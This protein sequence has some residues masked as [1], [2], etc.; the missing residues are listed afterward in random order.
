MAG[1]RSRPHRS[2]DANDSMARKPD[3]CTHGP[4]QAPAFR[5]RESTKSKPCGLGAKRRPL[6]PE[7]ADSESERVDGV[8]VERPHGPLQRAG[9]RTRGRAGARRRIVHTVEP[10]R[11]RRR[12]EGLHA[13]RAAELQRGPL[14]ARVAAAAAHARR[15]GRAGGQASC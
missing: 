15:V 6:P 10:R 13:L 5:L 1:Q 3:T 2:R 7:F 9:P 8:T 4:R 11:C 14:G 12:V